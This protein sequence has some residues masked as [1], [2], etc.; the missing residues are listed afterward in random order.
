MRLLPRL[1]LAVL[2]LGCTY[3]NREFG[4]DETAGAT[5]LTVDETAGSSATTQATASTGPSTGSTDPTGATTP[6]TGSTTTDPT[7]QGT[8]SSTTDPTSA[9]TTSSTTDTSTTAVTT[10]PTTGSTTQA[11]AMCPECAECVGNQCVPNPNDS[12]CT[13]AVS[14]PCETMVWGLDIEG[15]QAS[16]RAQGV[17]TPTCLSGQCDYLCD[18]PGDPLATCDFRCI[19]PNHNCTMGAP[20]ASISTESVCVTSGETQGCAG[21]CAMKDMFGF[22]FHTRGCGIDGSCVDGPVISCGLFVCG[23]SGCFTQCM[24][25]AQCVPGAQCLNGVCKFFNP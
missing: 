4:D 16:C 2:V 18:A 11:C 10:G 13:N 21:S 12:L 19:D 5:A 14:P 1:G 9:G 22:E 3:P 20:S 25:V 8:G 24:S 6:G 7:T 17:K 23:G 15:E